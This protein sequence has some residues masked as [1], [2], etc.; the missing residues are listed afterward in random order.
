M[1]SPTMPAI[2]WLFLH[3]AAFVLLATC[4]PKVQ[5]SDLKVEADRIVS[6]FARQ[7]GTP[8][9]SASV[10]IHGQQV[11]STGFGFAD[12]EQRVAVDPARTKFRIG[13]VAKPLTAFAL[14]QLVA[15][16]KVDLGQDVRRYVPQFPPK[17]HTFTVAQL[18]GHLAC[19]R[20][21]A[22][23]E[24][25]SRTRYLSAAAA[26]EVFQDDAL[27]CVPG[28]EWRYSSYGYNLLSVV[29]ERAAEKPF[30]EHL[31]QSVLLPFGMTS[32]EPDRIEEVVLNRG[33]YYVRRDGQLYNEPEVDNS[34]KWASGGMLSTTDDL[35]RF[36]LAL[37]NSPQVSSAMREL[38]WTEQ[39]T[40]SGETTGYG[41]GFRVVV[42]KEGTRWIGHGGGS[43]G[44]TTQFWLFPETG[45]VI[46]VA[47]NLTELDYTDLI[48]RLRDL[49][50]GL[51]AN[52]QDS[53][54]NGSQ[55]MANYSL[56]RT[57]Q[58]LRD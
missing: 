40:T 27:V 36:G 35:V 1:Q 42:D 33:R 31:D 28:T 24:A 39:A 12:V 7:S 53:P 5:A 21:Y 25:Y 6:E 15:Q 4:C 43:I 9:L 2:R 47:S 30:L 29:I 8:G 50:V 11:W 37:M 45:M 10:G 34:N 44:G 26:L 13:S 51:S 19:V 32:T 23:D 57:D 14:V 54:Q 56:K 49:F 18:A 22:G 38:L 52:Q 20:H 41:I 3:C 58:S 55:P 46:A 16:G 17:E 48:P